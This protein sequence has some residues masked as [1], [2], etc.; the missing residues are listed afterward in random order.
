MMNVCIDRVMLIMCGVVFVHCCLLVIALHVEWV[1]VGVLGW[2][3][4][5]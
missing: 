4:C 1:F 2:L 5:L 3:V